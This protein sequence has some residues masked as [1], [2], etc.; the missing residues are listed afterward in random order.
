LVNV[1]MCRFPERFGSA[2]CRIYCI[3]AAVCIA[4]HQSMPRNVRASTRRCRRT[5]TRNSRRSLAC[6]RCWDCGCPSPARSRG[7]PVPAEAAWP[8]LPL[9]E[10]HR[11]SRI[12]HHDVRI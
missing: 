9:L 12:A 8:G 7:C 3:S 4:T 11:P 1:I 6:S 10:E 2:L 5:T